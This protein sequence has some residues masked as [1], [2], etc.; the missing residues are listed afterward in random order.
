MLNEPEPENNR[1]IRIVH[2]KKEGYDILIDRT[3]KW[4]NPFV[5]R[6]DGTRKQVI[7]KY[8]RWIL[9]QPQLIADLSE[10]K[11]K[12]LGCWCHPKACHGD[13]LKELV[14]TRND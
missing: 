3:S 12:V 7:A 14:E 6:R 9:T 10:L 4:G 11:N 8:G 5:I 13:I 2:N 1:M